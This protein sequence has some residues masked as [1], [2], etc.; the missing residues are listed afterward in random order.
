[1][2]GKDGDDRLLGGGDEDTLRGNGGNDRLDGGGENDVLIGGDGADIFAF[3]ENFA[4]DTIKDFEDGSDR[5]S[6]EGLRGLNGG[7]AL[8]FDQLLV[9]D[10]GGST[11][12][13]LDLDRNGIADAIDFDGDGHADPASI[14]LLNVVSADITAAD[15]VF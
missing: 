15:F 10:N 4:H 11:T 7:D 12:I 2:L 5:I 9:T 1:L 6:L 3:S 13:E 14:A 8:T